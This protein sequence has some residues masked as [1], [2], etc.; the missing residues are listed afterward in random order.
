MRPSA[1]LF[2]LD[3]TL[4]SPRQHGNAFWQDAI[5]QTCR[6]MCPRDRP[7][8]E[9]IRMLA[10]AV[11]RSARHY[12]SDPVRHKTGR[13]NIATTRLQILDAGL[14]A[15]ARFDQTLRR[16]IADYCGALITEMTALYPDAIE[17]LQALNAEGIPLALITNG[18]A[19]AQRAKIRRF[20]LEPHF[21]HIQI[22]GEVGIG[23]PEP[24]AYR[25]ALAALEAEP[26]ETWMVGDNL[27]WEVAA[28]QALGIYAIW[29]DPKCRGILPTHATVTPD[30]I[31]TRLLDLV[32]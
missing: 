11:E 31:L 5:S 22:E 21:L 27:E 26:E 32:D 16:E 1:I 30:R 4:I 18:A 8:L 20:A 25:L 14:G 29:R 13:M 9:E 3:D 7:D 19:E 12:W 6:T 23:K 2:D 15:D 28:P 24:E 17:T 10:A